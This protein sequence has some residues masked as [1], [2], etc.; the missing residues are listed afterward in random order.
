MTYEEKLEAT[1]V[2]YPF[3]RW[4]ESFFPDENDVGGMEQYAPENCDGAADIMNELIADLVSAGENA[5]ESEK[6]QLF[7]KAVEAYNDMDDEI[8]GFIEIGE[9]DD[10]CE[11][12]DIITMAAGLNPEDYADGEGI[13]DLWR[14]W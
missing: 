9:R 1:K 7:E 6:M 4:S 14:R 5:A 8:A 11:I 2:H 13:T 3:N 12:F 10:L